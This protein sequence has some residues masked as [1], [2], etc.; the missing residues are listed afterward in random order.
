MVSFI[1]LA[2]DVIVFFYGY[3]NEN[4]YDNNVNGYFACISGYTDNGTTRLSHLVFHSEG[5]FTTLSEWSTR[6]NPVWLLRC[7]L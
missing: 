6:D 1:C 4:Y 2:R 7:R 3:V 5:E